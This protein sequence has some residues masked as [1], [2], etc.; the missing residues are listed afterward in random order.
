MVCRDRLSTVW[1]MKT[2]DITPAQVLALVQAIIGLL[3]AFGVDLTEAQSVAVIALSGVLAS[4]LL[5]GDK[6]IRV[7][8]NNRVGRSE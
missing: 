1:G 8:R 3:I 2:P 4:M 5:K 6:D 7:A